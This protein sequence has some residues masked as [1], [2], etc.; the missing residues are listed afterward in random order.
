MVAHY[1]PA[2]GLLWY[3]SDRGPQPVALDV[4]DTALKNGRIYALPEGRGS[5]DA[6]EMLQE[7]QPTAP[8]LDTIAPAC[9]GDLESTKPA[10]A[11]T[12]VDAVGLEISRPAPHG[13]AADQAGGSA[14]QPCGVAVQP[15]GSADQP[16][17]SAP[18]ADATSGQEHE[19]AERH[20]AGETDTAGP[21][22]EGTEARSPETGRK[23]GRKSRPQVPAGMLGALSATKDGRCPVCGR[24]GM[25][26]HLR[27]D[28][29]F[30]EIGTHSQ[31][32]LD[33]ACSACHRLEH[34]EDFQKREDWRAAREHAIRSRGR[35]ECTPMPSPCANVEA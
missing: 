21:V 17:A 18:L 2:K 34:R 26:L 3:E 31:G 5:T 25:L 4:L 15:G 7:Q 35:T 19:S 9:T 8:V 27:H 16:L 6:L 1:D 33:W 13:T 12:L 11:N 24:W 30:S 20:P 29:P 14:S 28:P 22:L 32:A 23:S 10:P